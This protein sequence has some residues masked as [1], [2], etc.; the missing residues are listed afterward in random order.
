MTKSFSTQIPSLD[1][2]LGD[3]LMIGEITEVCGEPGIGKTQF[4]YAIADAT[5]APS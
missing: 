1:Q 3:G 5:I 4:A 2:I